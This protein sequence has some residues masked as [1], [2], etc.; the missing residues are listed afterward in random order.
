MAT[1][2]TKAHGGRLLPL[3]W[4]YS[5]SCLGGQAW[6]SAANSGVACL[7]TPGSMRCSQTRESGGVAYSVE[8]SYTST[9]TSAGHLRMLQMLERSRLVFTYHDSR[10]TLRVCGSPTYPLTLGYSVA[11][12]VVS[13]RLSGRTLCPDPELLPQ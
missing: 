6:L 7:E 2:F 5:Y 12:G 10:D 9:D 1:Q 11:D 3:N 13:V 4:I 8:I